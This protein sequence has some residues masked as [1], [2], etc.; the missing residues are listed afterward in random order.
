MSHPNIVYRPGERTPYF[1]S[2]YNHND[3]FPLHPRLPEEV[4]MATQG[5]LYW[6]RYLAASDKASLAVAGIDQDIIRVREEV[7]AVSLAIG[8]PVGGELTTPGI[9]IPI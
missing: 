8:L 3:R 7:M 6:A 2:V 4:V 9:G 5:L 1:A